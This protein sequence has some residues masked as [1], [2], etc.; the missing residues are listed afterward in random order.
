[1]VHIQNSPEILDCLGSILVV[2]CQD[3]FQETFVAHLSVD[4]GVLL[5]DSVDDNGRQ[6]L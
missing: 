5:E 6:S 3:E 4:S 2:H 1:M